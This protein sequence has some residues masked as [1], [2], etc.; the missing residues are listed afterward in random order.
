MFESLLKRTSEP[1]LTLLSIIVGYI[2]SSLTC[3]LAIIQAAS[4]QQNIKVSSILCS[5]EVDNEGKDEKRHDDFPPVE[6]DVVEALYTKFRA[7]IKSSVD[8]EQFGAPM[9][10][11]RELIKRV[12]D[13][14]WN[15]LTRSYYKDRA[16]LQSIYNYLT[17][18]FES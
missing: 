4:L 9:Y 14:I 5:S 6:L 17:G 13:V 11:T 12:S 1:D 3:N 7:I 8:L 15:T 16:H 10:A 18:N 2:E